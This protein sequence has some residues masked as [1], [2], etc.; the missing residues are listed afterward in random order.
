MS[1]EEVK[2]V[3][4]RSFVVRVW[5]KYEIGKRGLRKVWTVFG[6][7]I[8]D[9]QRDRVIRTKVL[10]ELSLTIW[11]CD[12]FLTLWSPHFM[13]THSKILFG[14]ELRQEKLCAWLVSIITS[15]YLQKP[16]FSHGWCR[17]VF[18]KIISILY[19]I[20][21]ATLDR[22][23]LC[24]CRWLAELVIVANKR[25]CEQNSMLVKQYNFVLKLYNIST[26]LRMP[27]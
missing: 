16:A 26:H 8:V 7:D 19:W 15:N 4:M 20:T 14:T 1:L 24:S 25:P 10:L 27:S 17:I 5:A 18:Q 3:H 21:S 13:R 12:C 22:Y 23:H 11:K 6:S 2:V 9:N